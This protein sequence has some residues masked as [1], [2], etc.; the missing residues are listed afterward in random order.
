MRKANKKAARKAK[1]QAKKAAKKM[2]KKNKRRGGDSDSTNEEFLPALLEDVQTTLDLSYIPQASVDKRHGGRHLKRS[3]AG[4]ANSILEGE[5]DYYKGKNK[6]HGGKG[7]KS[8]GRHGD[9]EDK[10]G[11]RGGHRDHHRG[12]KGGHLKWCI[13]AG[14]SIFTAICATFL[15]IFR[16]FISTFRSYHLMKETHA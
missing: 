2:M 6:H 5:H 10:N 4:Q 8:G 1:K 9:H 13:A 14:I 7:K 3:N 11:R 12:E 15:G 16:K